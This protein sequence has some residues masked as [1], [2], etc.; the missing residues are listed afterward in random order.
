MHIVINKTKHGKKIYNSI[1]LRESYREDG[2]VKKRTIAN[3]SNCH[4]G[5]I[6]AIKLALKH[7]DDLGSLINVKEDVHL[8]EGLSV[9]AVWTI[10]QLAKRLGIEKGLG[11]D[12]IGKLALWQVMARVLDQGSRLSA[13]RL[14]KTHAACDVLGIG[15]GFHEDDLYGNLAWLSDHQGLIEDRLFAFRKERGSCELF[16]YDVTSSYLEGTD[17]YFG[18]YGYNRD[19]K[20]GKQQIV[21][22][23]LCDGDGDPV[24]VEVFA[25]NTQD[26]KTFASQVRKVAGRFGCERVTFVGDRGMIK[27][28]QI[29]ELPEGFHYITAITKAQVD[30]LIKQGHIQLGLFDSGLCEIQTP[31]GIRYILRNNPVRAE[32]LSDN[33]LAKRRSIEEALIRKNDYLSAHPRAKVSVAVKEISRKI[34]QLRVD[35]WLTVRIDE[36]ALNLYVN[37]DALKEESRLDGCYV[38]K[39]DLPA[40]AASKETI[41]SRYKDLAA[42][43][44]AFRTCKTDL[45]EVRPVFVRN[46]KSTRGHVFVVMLAYMIIRHLRESWQRFDVTVEEGLKQLATLTSIEVKIKG[47]GSCLKIP[48]PREQSR[49]LLE[50]L[51]ISMP[52]VLPHKEVHVDTRKKIQERRKPR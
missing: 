49:R 27:T 23:L 26:V 7:K 44:Q 11:N 5:E 35:K 41:H 10:Y 52:S 51:N 17:N 30:S 28:T 3:L 36:R 43:E 13:V 39:T 9:G 21:I 37:E 6:E 50:A 25:G 47:K 38:I 31:D 20:R 32:E 34:K 45:L 1:L 4:P 15:E 46:E 8:E 18:A 16:L 19:G 42:V 12:S 40:S 33:R 22:G 48:R 29:K 14:A 24:S 2:K